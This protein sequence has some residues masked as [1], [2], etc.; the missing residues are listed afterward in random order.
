[1]NKD[2]MGL[3]KG[4]GTGLAAGMAVGYVGSQL[5]NNQKQVKKK[6]TKAAHAVGTLIDDVHHIFKG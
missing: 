3:I 1:M 4:I 6:A 2:S 5:M